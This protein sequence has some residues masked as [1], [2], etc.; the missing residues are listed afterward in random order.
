MPTAS[1]WSLPPPPVPPLP[2]PPP[3]PPPPPNPRPRRRARRAANPLGR[4]VAARPEAPAPRRDASRV[5]PDE[6]RH[7]EVEHLDRSRPVLLARQEQIGRLQIP[8]NDP[9]RVRLG[10]G[11]ERLQ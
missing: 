6:L 8:V 4:D 5:R 7:T 2:S 9:E 10:H 1:R 3:P 11:L